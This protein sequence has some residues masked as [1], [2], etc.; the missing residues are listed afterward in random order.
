MERYRQVLPRKRKRYVY[1]ARKRRNR[2]YLRR[3]GLFAKANDIDVEIDRKV[4]SLY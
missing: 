4:F 3:L 1:P 2:L